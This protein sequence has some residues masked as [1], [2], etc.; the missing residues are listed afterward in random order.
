MQQQSA[1]ALRNLA[2]HP[3][4]QHDIAG[5]GAIPPLVRMSAGPELVL[6]QYATAT[7][8]ALAMGNSLNRRN[9]EQAKKSM[10]I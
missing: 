9:I 6:R 4:I 3:D 2:L 7:L 1:A 8:D 5:A 10:G